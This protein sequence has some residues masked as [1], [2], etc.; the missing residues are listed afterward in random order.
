MYT[1]CNYMQDLSITSLD[2]KITL[3]MDHRT[4]NKI[5]RNKNNVNRTNIKY[6]P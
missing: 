3:R 1:K 4:S 5:R 6:N 2:N